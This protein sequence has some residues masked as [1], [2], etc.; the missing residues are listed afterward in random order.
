MDKVEPVHEDIHVDNIAT[1]KEKCRRQYCGSQKAIYLVDSEAL[2]EIYTSQKWRR[3]EGI[4]IDEVEP[5]HADIYID[6]YESC[7]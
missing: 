1:L 6:E 2:K 7:K 4:Y 5:T 3:E